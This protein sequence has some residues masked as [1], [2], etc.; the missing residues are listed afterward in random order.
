MSTLTGIWDATLNTPLGPIS[1]V[2]SFDDEN[3]AT[4]SGETVPLTNLAATQADDG[5]VEATWG[6]DVTRPLPIHLD[7]TVSFQGDTLSGS[8]SAGMLMPSGALQG[9]RRP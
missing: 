5:S 2:F 9:A 6:A 8:A 4:A 3:T 1:I 7:F